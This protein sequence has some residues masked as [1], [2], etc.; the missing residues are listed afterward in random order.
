MVRPPRRASATG[1]VRAAVV[2]ESLPIRTGSLA[3]PGSRSA[4]PIA[5]SDKGWTR[6]RPGARM[7][8]NRSRRPS[9]VGDWEEGLDEG[10]D[11]TVTCAARGTQ[12]DDSTAT[13]PR[14][15]V[16][17]AE[18]DP[19]PGGSIARFQAT[20]GSQPEIRGG[21]GWTDKRPPRLTSRPSSPACRR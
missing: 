8:P 5:R 3:A 2:T 14:A 21:D 6:S 13:E 17:G 18:S 7:P 11:S 9:G 12:G 15:G 4:Y 1:S 19:P 20:D 10:V 16:Q